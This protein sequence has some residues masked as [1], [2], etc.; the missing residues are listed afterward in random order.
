MNMGWS[1]TKKDRLQYLGIP[2]A[3]QPVP[4]SA[5]LPIHDPPKKYEIVKDYV[6]EEEFVKP[7]T[8]NDPDFGAED[9][10]EPHKLN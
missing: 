9:L 1:R 3:I 5:D 2:S 8:S 7:Q 6:E 4:H 10:N